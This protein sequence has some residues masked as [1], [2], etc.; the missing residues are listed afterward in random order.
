MI[1]EP[2]QVV[3]EDMKV[4]STHVKMLECTISKMHIRTT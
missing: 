2:G 3:Q 1:N 4:A